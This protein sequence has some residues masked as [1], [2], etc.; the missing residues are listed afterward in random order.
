MQRAVVVLMNHLLL[1]RDKIAAMSI[2]LKSKNGCLRLND[3][4]D[5]PLTR[6]PLQCSSQAVILKHDTVFPARHQQNG[7][8]FNDCFLSLGCV[9]PDIDLYNCE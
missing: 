1:P 6:I 7:F 8:S 2:A 9:Y 4:R 3:G 5:H